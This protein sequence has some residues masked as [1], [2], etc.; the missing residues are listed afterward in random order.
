MFRSFILSAFLTLGFGAST[1][2]APYPPQKL[3]EPVFV[4]NI[5]A[6]E[7][8][9]ESGDLWYVA[10]VF[11]GNGDYVFVRVRAKIYQQYLDVHEQATKAEDRISEFM[12]G[13]DFEELF[14]NK[15]VTQRIILIAAKFR[16]EVTSTVL[17]LIW[18]SCG[19]FS[20]GGQPLCS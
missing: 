3:L 5:V 4:Q 1:S 14:L 19:Q 6:K 8:D 17:W 10:G 18:F 2:A 11:L 15:G 7:R 16:K 9:P 20:A 13:Q 12:G